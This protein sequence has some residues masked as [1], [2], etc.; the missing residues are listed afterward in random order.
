MTNILIVEDSRVVVEKLKDDLSSLGYTNLL[1]ISNGEDAIE[2]IKEEPIDLIIMDII[3]DGTIDGIETSKIINDYRSIP[4]IYLTNDIRNYKRLPAACVYLNKPFTKNELRYNIEIVLEQYILK[5]KLHS[6]I[7]W[8]SALFKYSTEAIVMFDENF[9]INGVNKKYKSLF[10]YDYDYFLN[11]SIKD[12]ISSHISFQGLKENFMTNV[13][14]ELERELVF[15][16][17]ASKHFLIK[18][19]PIFDDQEFIG[20]Y[21]TYIDI[22]DLKRKEQKIRYISE[23]DVMTGLFNRRYFQKKLEA[24]TD[25]HN[26][27]I[28][29]I[30]GDINNLKYINDHYGHSTGDQYIQLAAKLL[31]EYLPED[32][33]V[34]RIGGDEFGIILINKD[35]DVC[36]KICREINEKSKSYSIKENLKEELSISL[37]YSIKSQDQISGE[38]LFNKADQNMYTNKKSMKENK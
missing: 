36:R 4:T 12:I 29:L 22:T 11:Q 10:P 19:I 26:N 7:Q 18:G 34:A 21:L 28:S 14:I 15:D 8:F 33:I 23:H 32:A 31:L 9:K 13:S 6:Q 5:R 25:I 16:L 24:L 35:Q 37:G 1:V 30:I 38:E 3:L 27:K 20:G 2:I 17:G